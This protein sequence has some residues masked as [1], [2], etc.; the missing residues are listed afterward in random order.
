MKKILFLTSIAT[1]NAPNQDFTALSKTMD[2]LLGDDFAVT[3]GVFSE[4]AYLAGGGMSKVWHPTA[5]WDVADFDLVVLRRVGDDLERAISIAHYLDAKHIPFI[6]QYLLAPGKGKLA[7]AFL[8]SAHGLPVPTTFFGSHSVFKQVF[9]EAAPF[10]F[11]MVLK[12]DNG[13]KGRDNYLIHTYDELLEKLAANPHLDLIAQAFIPN[14]GDL[15]ILVL[16]GTPRLAI[17]RKGKVGSHLNNTSQGGSASLVPLSSLDAKLLVHCE[18]AA[19]LELLQVAGVDVVIDEETNMHYFLEVNRAPQLA[20]GALTSE[21]LAAYAAMIVELTAEDAG[22]RLHTIGGVEYVTLADSGREVPA[23]ID[24]GAN[25][26]AVWA[27]D[28]V[29]G[30]DGTLTFKLF[31]KQSEFYTGETIVTKDFAE[32]VIASSNGAIEQRYKVKI[33]FMLGGRRVRAFFT[34]A[35]RSMQ[36]YP[37]LIGRNVLKGKFIVNVKQGKTLRAAER[38]R[39]AALKQFLSPEKGGE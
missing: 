5:G 28:V 37:I 17:L 1:S 35:N 9:A 36:V 38:L 26:S 10:T 24:T 22:R 32:T 39:S 34:L 13:S 2:Q 14:K 25:T 3:A 12:A 7:G 29:E 11:P 23:R 15:R 6:D 21:K 8:R 20:T 18:R 16:N 33:S 31:D 19:R 27:S 30:K 4:L